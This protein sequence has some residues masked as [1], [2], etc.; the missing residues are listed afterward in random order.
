MPVSG[1]AGPNRDEAPGDAAPTFE[2]ALHR[3][4][5]IVQRLERGE[6]TLDE[7]LSA[8]REGSELVRFCLER[9]NAAEKAVQLLM[10]GENGSLVLKAAN[11]EDTAGEPPDA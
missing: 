3:L 9:L 11:L 10:V 4:E 7:S 6:I 5:D 1:P 2:A 8:F